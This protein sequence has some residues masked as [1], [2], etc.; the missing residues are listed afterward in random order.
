M[1]P[2]ISNA[3]F[4]GSCSAGERITPP[5]CWPWILGCIL[6]VSLV[7]LQ[8]IEENS[9]VIYIKASTFKIIFL[10]IKGLKKVNAGTL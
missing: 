10:Y 6:E 8:F 7:S 9:M 1:N 3:D 5:L 4:T 2:Y